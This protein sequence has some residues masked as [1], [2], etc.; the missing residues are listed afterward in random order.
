MK[1]GKFGLSLPSIAVIVFVF[2][3]LRMPEAVLLITAFAFLAERDGWLNKQ[4][5][6]ALLL[7]TTYYVVGLAL[8]LVFD[9]FGK[10]FSTAKAYGALSVISDIHSW[11][12]DILY[13]AL[14]ALS[15]YAILRLIQGKGADIPLLAKMSEGDFS[16][17]LAREPK[18]A[19]IP[20]RKVAAP[21]PPAPP[22]SP[23]SCPI[24]AAPLTE[25]SQFCSECGAKIA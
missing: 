23:A 25:G 24:C 9:I 7:I 8:S 14:L 11:A 19:A 16:A 6:Q 18:P 4:V 12:G 10:I 5:V 21:A 15:V 20:A 22:A 13:W 3:G 17:A 2:V 1:Q